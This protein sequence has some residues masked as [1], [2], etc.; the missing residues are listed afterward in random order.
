MVFWRWYSRFEHW[1][2]SDSHVFN[3][4]G[5]YKVKLCVNDSDQCTEHDITIEAKPAPAPVVAENTGTSSGGG[6]DL[7]T[8]TGA[9]GG[10][11]GLLSSMK[12]DELTSSWLKG[13]AFVNISPKKP[14]ELDVAKVYANRNGKV[15]I[16]LT[17]ND[18]K[19]TGVIK[20]VQVNP[21]PTT[22]YLTDLAIILTPDKKYT[23]MIK[24]SDQ[25]SDLELENAVKCSPKPLKS[26]IVDV[27]YND[28]FI[29]YD[30]KFYY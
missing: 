11:V 25:N 4:A 21:G 17:N 14:M 15:D 10:R 30:L 6:F 18:S 26:D 9:D 2:R 19:E 23:L 24:P 7:S 1:E 3:K 20:N 5:K 8:Y 16:I 28:K 12:C 13:A 29:L 22:I 27:S